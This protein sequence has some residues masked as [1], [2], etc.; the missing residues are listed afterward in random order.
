MWIAERVWKPPSHTQV[1][2]RIKAWLAFLQ[3]LLQLSLS[4]KR[5][6]PRHPTSTCWWKRRK[7]QRK[8][9]YTDHWLAFLG[10][11]E[12]ICQGYTVWHYSL[13]WPQ[14]LICP[15]HFVFRTS[16]YW[17]LVD[18]NRHTSSTFVGLIWLWQLPR[19][20]GWCTNGSDTSDRNYS[21]FVFPLYQLA[22]E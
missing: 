2:P 12:R 14:R 22:A 4:K 6:C 5:S 9:P 3:G 21:H 19:T 1:H 18:F 11:Y 10:V 16:R 17:S 15:I 20:H 13:W 8:M 7:I